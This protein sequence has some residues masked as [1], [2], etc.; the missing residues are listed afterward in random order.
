MGLFVRF[1]VMDGNE[2]DVV[3]VGIVVG[4]GFWELVICINWGVEVMNVI[5]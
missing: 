3:F 2:V 1:R 5:L 4:F